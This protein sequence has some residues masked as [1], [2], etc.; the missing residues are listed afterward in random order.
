MGLGLVTDTRT[1]RHT[2]HLMFDTTAQKALCGWKR[3]DPATLRYVNPV[4]VCLTC[5]RIGAKKSHG[6]TP[7]FKANDDGTVKKIGVEGDIP[8]GVLDEPDEGA[9]GFHVTFTGFSVIELE[10]EKA[11]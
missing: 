9:T 4:R 1:V 2:I 7:I 3:K 11:S 10:E 5:Q 6:I 8:P